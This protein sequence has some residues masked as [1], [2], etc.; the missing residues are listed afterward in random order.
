[1]GL[2]IYI[3]TNIT[4]MRSLME[5]LGVDTLLGEHGRW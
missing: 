4:N 2:N 3:F 5:H 1:M